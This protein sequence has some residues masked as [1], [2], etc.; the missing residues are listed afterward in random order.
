[1]NLP[2]NFMVYTSYMFNTNVCSQMLDLKPLP[3]PRPAPEPEYKPTFSALPLWL[4]KPII[5]TSQDRSRFENLGISE[6]L[7][8]NLHKNGYDEAFAIPT[9]DRG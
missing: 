1:M 3:Q 7:L 6:R 2:L 4:S 8:K 9:E 5:A